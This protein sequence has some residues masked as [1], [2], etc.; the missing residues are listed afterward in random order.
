V[1]KSANTA[2][3]DTLV[4]WISPIAI[5]PLDAIAQA[6]DRIVHHAKIVTVDAQFRIAEAMAMRGERV[7]AV[8]PNDEVLKLADGKTQLFDL[9]GKTVLP[10]LID[11]HV[12]AT[13]AAE[14]EFDHTIPDMLSIADVLQYIRGRAELLVDGEWI[15]VGQ[16]FVTRL[17][18]QRFPTRAELDSVA[19]NNPVY[20][21][22]GP[23]A[24][25]NSLTLKLSPISNPSG[26]GSTAK[27]YCD[28]S[29]KNARS[30]SNPIVN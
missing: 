21:R 25:L 8:G 14:Y 26:C 9:K 1:N 20:F 7:V 11:S 24:A 23:D 10:A 19:P 4:R 30:T 3:F 5:A 27:H 28:N 17:N 15:S 16:V 2:F 6:P 12:H 18:E 13:G 22:T 29:A